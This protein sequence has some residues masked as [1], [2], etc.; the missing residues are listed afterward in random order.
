MDD[1][2]AALDLVLERSIDIPPAAVW[3]AWTDPQALMKWFTPAPWTTVECEID[4]RPGGAFRTLMKSPE[5]ETFPHTGC[6][7]EVV[8]HERLVWTSALLPGFRPAA[9]STPVPHFTAVITL[10]PQAGGTLYRVTAKHA[11]AAGAKAHAEMGFH[12]GWGTALD[13][14]V[15]AAKAG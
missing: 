3:K 4:L 2:T 9:A 7:L 10:T 14:L 1:N 15:A 5:G 8:P 6:Y 12:D 11:D 13:Q